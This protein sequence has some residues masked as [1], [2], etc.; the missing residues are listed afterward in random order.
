MDALIRA[1]STAAPHINKCIGG[2]IMANQA[3]FN[4]ESPLLLDQQIR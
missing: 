3:A 2:D 1:R 4:W